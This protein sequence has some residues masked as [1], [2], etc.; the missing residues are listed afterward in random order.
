MGGHEAGP[1]SPTPHCHTVTPPGH[2]SELET[3][4]AL[5]TGASQ[6]VVYFSDTLVRKEGVWE[7]P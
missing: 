2:L 1:R 3:P 6:P 4:S 7:P 5:G